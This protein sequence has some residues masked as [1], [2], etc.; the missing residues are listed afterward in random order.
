MGQ[1]NTGVH[2]STET[3]GG[4]GGGVIIRNSAMWGE[5]LYSR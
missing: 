3:G 5:V 4:G 2:R 1:C